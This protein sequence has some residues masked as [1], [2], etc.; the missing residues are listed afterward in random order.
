[1]AKI[2]NFF[3]SYYVFAFAF[4]LYTFARMV[5]IGD[6]FNDTTWQIA[7]GR[8]MLQFGRL[9]TMSDFSW[10][11]DGK[12]VEYQNH[13][14]L[15]EIILYLFSLI[16]YGLV[17]FKALST[18][19]LG[20]FFIKMLSYK[21]SKDTDKPGIIAVIALSMLY[22]FSL[23][24]Y[25]L[26]PYIW[27]F[28]FFMWMAYALWFDHKWLKSLPVLG[29]LW[30]NMH[31]G[32]MAM[33]VVMVVM[34]FAG[35]AFDKAFGKFESHKD[36]DLKNVALWCSA[37]YTCQIINP[38]GIN[39]LIY[40]FVWTS[41]DAMN[42]YII[43][44][45]KMSFEN[46]NLNASVLL[47]TVVIFICMLW[48]FK[49]VNISELILMA[50]CAVLA[51]MHVRHFAYAILAFVIFSALHIDDIRFKIED[52]E[53]IS[54]I[55]FLSCL[56]I[57]FNAVTIFDGIRELPKHGF[58]LAFTES[59]I[60]IESGGITATGRISADRSEDVINFIDDI[61]S[62]YDPQRLYTTFNLGGIASYCD[63]K[64]YI[65]GRFTPY[66]D[67]L[68]EYLIL[69]DCKEGFSDIISERNFDYYLVDEDNVL[70]KDYI[71]QNSDKF[72]LV[73]DSGFGL[74]CYKYQEG[75]SL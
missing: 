7:D 59:F 48:K 56:L 67:V 41:N 16:P 37:G 5:V 49:Q 64:T 18:G 6:A 53:K 71:S 9:L 72:I 21:K 17:L 66:A 57:I 22:A 60:G 74:K 36:S 3:S 14:W 47:L 43:E 55:W 39:M 62:E 31:G 11:A 73:S 45:R 38:Y 54:S 23:N 65:D 63:I 20:F 24:A 46:G 75:S 29:I 30:A 4:V 42:E 69:T 70:Y 12:V 8:M 44:W 35:H 40:P 50:G 28:I 26:R 58:C 15:Y 19:F 27:G 10:L 33:Y 13:E 61:K 32:S 2:K 68:D 34:Y 1:M 25:F 52:G 51:S